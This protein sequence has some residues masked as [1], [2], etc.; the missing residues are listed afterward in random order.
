[1]IQACMLT[2]PGCI[3]MYD[4]VSAVARS[5]RWRSAAVCCHGCPAIKEPPHPLHRQ[6]FMK[7]GTSSVALLGTSQHLLAAVPSRFYLLRPQLG[8]DKRHCAGAFT[9]SSGIV[10]VNSQTSRQCS[11]GCALPRLNTVRERAG[12]LSAI[13]GTRCHQT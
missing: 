7:L 11:V 8:P 12:P 3:T 10:P 2:P 9:R 13:H 6:A 5:Q 1:L 4:G